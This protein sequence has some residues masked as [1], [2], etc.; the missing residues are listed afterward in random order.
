M[1]SRARMT[2]E[3]DAKMNK[4][5]IAFAYFHPCDTLYGNHVSLFNNL[6]LRYNLYESHPLFHKFRG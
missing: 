3:P 4:V 5:R 6:H 2:R 1:F